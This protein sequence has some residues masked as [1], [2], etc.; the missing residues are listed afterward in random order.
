MKHPRILK[1]GSVALLV[2]VLVVGHGIVFYR[3]SS[4]MARAVVLG[5]ILLVLLKHVGLLGPFYALFKRRSQ[6]RP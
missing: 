1:Y 5:L 4:H 3:L 6:N 2:G